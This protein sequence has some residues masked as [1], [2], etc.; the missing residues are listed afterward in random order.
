MTPGAK[1]TDWAAIRLRMEVAEM[2]ME[3]AL[4]PPKDR[5]KKI[6]EARA[7]ALARPVKDIAKTDGLDVVAF[8]LARETYAIDPLVYW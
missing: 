3:D 1:P 5:A 4:N 8:T 6:M 2:E 7:K